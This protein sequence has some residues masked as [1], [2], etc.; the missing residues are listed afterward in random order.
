M[1]DES[2]LFHLNKSN[3]NLWVLLL[4]LLASVNIIIRNPWGFID[5][6]VIILLFFAYFGFR[7]KKHPYRKLCYYSTYSIT[8]PGWQFN[9]AQIRSR[10]S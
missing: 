4:Y 2:S 9:K 7:H 1:K 3:K 8:S 10:F 6:L 5:E